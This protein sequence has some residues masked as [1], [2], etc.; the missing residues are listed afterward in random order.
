MRQATLT[1]TKTKMKDGRVILYSLYRFA[2]V[3]GMSQF[4]LSELIEAT[5]G[6]AK[7]FGL[8]V[9][10]LEQFLNGLSANYPEFLDVTF[11][12]DLEKISLMPVKTAE[13]IL[14]LFE[15]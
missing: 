6:S 10:E 7:I 1:R 5:A 2:E 8:N 3:R 11:T 12:H 15:V 14:K 13:D 4:S 9:E